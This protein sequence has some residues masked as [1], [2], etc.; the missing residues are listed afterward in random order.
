MQIYLEIGVLLAAYVLGSIPF[1]LLVVK[2]RTG[3]DIRVIESGR[4]G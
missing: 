4:T 1:G 2:W 3:K